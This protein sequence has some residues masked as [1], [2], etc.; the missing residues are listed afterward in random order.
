MQNPKARAKEV[1]AAIKNLPLAEKIKALAIYRY[2]Q[3][4][5][6][7]EEEKVKEVKELQKKYLKLEDPIIKAQNAIING[8]KALTLDEL[9]NKEKYLSEEEQKSIETNLSAKKIPEYWLKAMKN[10][11]VLKEEVTASDQEA[12]KFLH[13]IHVIDEEG[14]DNF[15]I[16]FTFTENPFFKNKEL[17]KKF[18]LKD[19]MPVKGEGTVIEWEQGKDLTKKEIKKKQ[20]NK[21]TG[22]SRVVTKIVDADS[23]FNF[24]G[25]VTVSEAEDVE[26]DEDVIVS[27]HSGT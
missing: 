21:K 4:I 1:E 23:F 2:Y 12:L 16:V 18:I 9:K 25:T 14:T 5:N 10:C 13:N 15:E 17:K 19:D 20:K 6:K 7:I 11:D 27:N 8:E 22:Q 26:A 3:E 24:F